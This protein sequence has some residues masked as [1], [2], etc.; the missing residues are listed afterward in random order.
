M[1][2]IDSICIQHAG[3]DRIVNFC[4]GDLAALSDEDAVDA[5]VVSAIPDDYSATPGSL[6]GALHRRGIS[7]AALAENKAVD[8]RQFSSCWLSQIIDEPDANFRRVLCFEPAVRGRATEVVGDIFRSIIPFTTGDPPIASIAM[9]LVA[10][11][12]QQEDSQGLLEAL[13]DAALH[14]LSTGV[15]LDRINIVAHESSDYEALAATFADIKRAHTEPESRVAAF[16]FDAFV[17]YS[18]ENKDAVDRL[19]RELLGAKPGLR[20][21]LDRLEL[22]PGAAWQQHIFESLDF[23][24]KVICL[25]SPAY[26]NSKICQEE[27]NM[28]LIRHRE[29]LNGVLL[30]VYLATANLPTYMRLVQYHDAREGEEQGLTQA[31]AALAARF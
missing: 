21:F 18:W 20:V 5:L 1:K 28:A 26:L 19:V 7:V 27:F 3:R 22:K 2:N 31:A 29:S 13:M 9:P 4:T 23:S 16:E 15:P 24:Q 17:S 11:G 30:P 6:I 8:L 25:Y 10:T 14:W 12:D